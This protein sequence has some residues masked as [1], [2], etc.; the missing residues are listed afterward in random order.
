MLLDHVFL[1]S[2]ILPGKP[3]EHGEHRFFVF[4]LALIVFASVVFF[5]I[6]KLN[7]NANN[8]K[9]NPVTKD[10]N[11]I[12]IKAQLYNTKVQLPE[13]VVDS[14]KAKLSATKVTVSKSQREAI[15]KQLEASR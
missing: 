1:K 11:I 6:Y 2:K 3:I 13:I 9:L 4:I 8:I 14:I 10:E 15:V 12:A 5:V 7:L